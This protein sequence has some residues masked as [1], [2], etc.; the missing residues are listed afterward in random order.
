MSRDGVSVEVEDAH[1]VRYVVFLDVSEDEEGD[2]CCGVFFMSD[3]GG[4]AVDLVGRGEDVFDALCDLRLMLEQRGWMLRCVGTDVDVYPSGMS[5]SMSGGRKVYR[6]RPGRPA[7]MADLVD[8][9]DMSVAQKGSTV[10][11][12]RAF[13][14]RWLE[15]LKRSDL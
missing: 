15:S 4:E 14:E 3:I 11:E 2:G 6:L 10:A 12:Q 5:R 8:V 1:G 7:A 13:F 9:F